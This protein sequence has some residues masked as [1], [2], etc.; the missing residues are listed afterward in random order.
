M[1]EDMWWDT[2]LDFYR[3]FAAGFAIALCLMALYRGVAPVGLSLAQRFFS[4]RGE[5]VGTAAFGWFAI[6]GGEAFSRNRPQRWWQKMR[7]IDWRAYFPRG[8]TRAVLRSEQPVA[9]PGWRNPRFIKDLRIGARFPKL[10]RDL[11][12]ATVE[13]T[14]DLP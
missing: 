1:A 5:L 2:V 11:D 8:I 4:A 6:F 9:R 12:R 7:S 13:P 3:V 14:L 10:R